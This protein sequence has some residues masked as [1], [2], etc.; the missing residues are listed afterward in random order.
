MALQRATS[1]LRSWLPVALLSAF[2]LVLLGRLVQLQ[3]LR[4]DEFAEAARSELDGSMVVYARRGSILDRNG[5]VLAM[6]VDT[7]DVYVRKD[8]WSGP[9]GTDHSAALATLLRISPVDLRTALE[10]SPSLNVRVATDVAFD[11]GKRV[12]AA[13]ITGVTLT[14]NSARTYPEG[15]LAAGILGL[16]GADNVGLAGLEV[17]YNT[18]LQG[19]PGRAFFE[20]DT[21]GEPIPFGRFVADEPEPGKDLVLTID[22]RLQRMAEAALKGAIQKHRAAGGALIMMDPRTGEILALASSPTLAYSTLDLSNPEQL[23]LLRNPVVSDLYEPGSVMKTITAAAAIDKGVVTPGTSYYDSGSIDVYGVTIKNWD[24]QVYGYQTMTGVLQH[25]INTGSVFMVR[26]LGQ[27]DFHRYLDAFGFGQPTRIDMPGEAAGIIRTPAQ[28]GYSPLDVLTQSFGQSISVT[29][30]QVMA[31]YAAVINGGNLLTP[32]LVRAIAGPGG[33][34]VEIKPEVV[35]HPITPRTSATVREMLHA[36]VEPGDYYYPGKP[37]D[38]TAG[39]KS[40]TANVPI[41]N[42]YDETQIASFIGFAPADDPEILI[43]VKLDRNADLLT[44]TQAASPVFAS[45]A[46][47][48]LHYLGVEP[49]DVRFVGSR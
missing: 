43:L 29:P 31:A 40:G 49:D 16:I 48:A 4:H 24:D 28:P 44:G 8:A 41:P 20:R 47:Q 12:Q 23:N 18:V 15:D 10:Q 6:S 36:V 39:G 30:L 9:T 3:V 37:R 5:N 26:A 21:T 25:S 38:Y 33:D 27:P 11:L 22:R 1:M 17:A 32:H 46:N 7:W 35:G 45:L 19:T 2:A 34:Y 14:P 13:E 42:G